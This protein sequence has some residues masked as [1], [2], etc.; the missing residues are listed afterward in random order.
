MGL[1]LAALLLCARRRIIAAHLEGDFLWKP[2][3]TRAAGSQSCRLSLRQPCPKLPL[4]HKPLLALW[5][6]SE[7]PEGA[8]LNHAMPART[9][10]SLRPGFATASRGYSNVR[11]LK[12]E[13][14]AIFAEG[15]PE[16]DLLAATLTSIRLQLK[17]QCWK[18]CSTKIVPGGI[19]SFD[20][21]EFWPTSRRKT[22]R[23]PGLPSAVARS[24]LCR[25]GQGLVIKR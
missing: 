16:K 4:Q 2:A 5:L 12:G 20:D 22:R 15:A 1:S 25:Q 14:P 24:F 11:I 19:V 18:P 17:W 8:R 9:G 3:H 21:Y 10:L 13:I 7:H 6:F 23:I